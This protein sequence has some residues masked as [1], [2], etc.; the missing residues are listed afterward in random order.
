MKD[1]RYGTPTPDHGPKWT[2][3]RGQRFGALVV[4]KKSEGSTWT[5]L[6]DCGATT[7]A[8]TGD[9]NRGSKISCG[10]SKIHH[11]SSDAGYAAAHQR[12]RQDRGP[13]TRQPCIDCDAPAYHWS[14]DHADPMEL[15][16]YG[17][18]ANPVAYSLDPDHYSPRCVPCHKR[19]DLG[20]ATSM[21]V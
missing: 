11:R 13:V 4:T 19:F 18:S 10:N 16:A 7:K 20:R 12:V 15:L 8:L 1:W 3:I 14:Y 6:C 9:L 2:D 5:C 17:L 21:A